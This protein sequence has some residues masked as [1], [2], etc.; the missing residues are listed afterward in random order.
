MLYTQTFD[1][2]LHHL[3]LSLP[4]PVCTLSG[5]PHCS[6]VLSLNWASDLFGKFKQTHIHKYTYVHAYI[7][8]YVY[9]QRRQL[10][11][12]LHCFIFPSEHCVGGVF[13]TVSFTTIPELWLRCFL[14]LYLNFKYFKTPYIPCCYQLHSFYSHEIRSLL[15]ACPISSFTLVF[16]FIVLGTNPKA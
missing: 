7:M 11:L 2:H 15:H 10:P 14:T 6:V 12:E 1:V 3:L 4:S 9:T 13:V 5:A 16:I 8:H